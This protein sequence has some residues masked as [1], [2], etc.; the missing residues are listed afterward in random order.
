MI[1]ATL[2]HI[3]HKY[4]LQTVVDDV[5]WE[6][7]AGQKIGLVGPNGAGKSTLLR[8][9]AGELK[10]DSGFVHRHKEVQVGYLAQD[11]VLDPNR[12][13][14]EEIMSAAKELVR[15]EAEMRRLEA[16]MADPQVY[17]D[18]TKLKR[19]LA[20]HARAQAEFERLDGY[21][22][23]SRARDALYTLGLDEKDFELPTDALSGG[24][25]K[26]VG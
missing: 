19:V 22:Y 17:E 11:P 6:I 7:Q 14:W 12:T 20:A 5:S 3:V 13:V 9:L 21:R 18:D 2:H 26:L 24:E 25:K 10:P 23:E 4:G 15:V 1:V 8:I 16:Q